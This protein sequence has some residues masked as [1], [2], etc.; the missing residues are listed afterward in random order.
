[1][2]GEKLISRELHQK[3]PIYGYMTNLFL[4][5]KFQHKG[6]KQKKKKKKKNA[7]SQQNHAVFLAATDSENKIIQILRKKGQIK[8]LNRIVIV[9]KGTY[10]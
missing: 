9:R 4:E 10:L 2:T 7:N 3:S 1:M 8:N 6:N 5:S